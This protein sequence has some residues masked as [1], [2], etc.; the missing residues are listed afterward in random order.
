MYMYMHGSG[1]PLVKTSNEVILIDVILSPKHFEMYTQMY[2][3]TELG[4]GTPLVK[5]S[6]ATY[7]EIEKY[8]YDACKE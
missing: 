3:V 1:I 4:S 5:T 2:Q 7:F 8:M 6:N